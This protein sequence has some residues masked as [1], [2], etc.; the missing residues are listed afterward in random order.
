MSL[1]SRASAAYRAFTGQAPVTLGAPPPSP[2]GPTG[3]RTRDR[4][5]TTI[6]DPLGRSV[7]KRRRIS[8]IA[9]DRVRWLRADIE[10][11]EA[12]ANSGQLQ[13]A[14]QIADWCKADLT[15][16]ALN[17]LLGPAPARGRSP[18]VATEATSRGVST[19]SSRPA[20]SKSS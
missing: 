5:A 17:A 1:A 12:A 19:I 16:L 11:A 7:G 2:I 9:V 4:I 15:R 10:R 8:P 3:E 20:S 6:N 14:A 18:P 13:W